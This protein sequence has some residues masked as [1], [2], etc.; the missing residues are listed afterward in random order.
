MTIDIRSLAGV[1]ILESFMILKDK[2]EHSWRG[3]PHG[4]LIYTTDG[5]M[6]VSINGTDTSYSETER[7][8]FYAG[9][10]EILGSK[11]V[12][13][14]VTNASSFERIGKPM[15]REAELEGDVLSLVAKGDF[16]SATLKWKK[17]SK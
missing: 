7:I 6:S 2:E 11:E 16:G 17:F 4:I 8:L 9:N 10:Y 3:A 13:H 1:W 14:S 12:A 5:Y 15:I